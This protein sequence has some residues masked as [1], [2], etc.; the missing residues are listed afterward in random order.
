[1]WVANNYANGELLLGPIYKYQKIEWDGMP[2][3]LTG[4]SEIINARQL[5]LPEWAMELLDSK[6]TED[7]NER[8]VRLFDLL[9]TVIR[10]NYPRYVGIRDKLDRDETKSK[11]L[12]LPADKKREAIDQIL[13]VLHADARRGLAAIG[14]PAG[15]GRMCNLNI[16]G[17]IDHIVFCSTSVTGM[18]E[19]R[20][21]VEL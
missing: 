18:F 14:L 3:Y 1:V 17:A 11:F 12:A 10:E 15:A 20:F 13:A 2:Y 19:K 8:L 4:D 16:G 6:E 21:K 9:R 5:Y 7:S